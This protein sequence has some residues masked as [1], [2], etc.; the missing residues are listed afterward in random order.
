MPF[1]LDPPWLAGYEI[2][3]EVEQLKSRITALEIS[4]EVVDKLLV[5]DGGAST[6]VSNALFKQRLLQCTQQRYSGARQQVMCMLGHFYAPA[7]VVI[8]SHLVKHEWASFGVHQTMFGFDDIDTVRNGLLLFKPFEWAFDRSK[9]CFVP[10]EL[11]NLV[12][13]ILDPSLREVKLTEALSSSC[14]PRFVEWASDQEVQQAVGDK[15]FGD[16]EGHWLVCCQGFQPFKRVL[17][18]HAHRAK[19][20]AIQQQWLGAEGFEIPDFWSESGYNK[21][22]I[23]NW[24]AEA[25][26]AV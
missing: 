19:R 3:A 21:A 9:I 26:A 10:D 17:C 1:F 14:G 11:D 8:A 13:H 22:G 20:Y 16:F 4:N 12:M 5:Y 24:L 2:A 6:R 7:P 15:T 25:E 23:I 18:F